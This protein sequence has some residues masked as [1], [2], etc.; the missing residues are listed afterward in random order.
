MGWCASGSLVGLYSLQAGHLVVNDIHHSAA[1]HE[2]RE[3]GEETSN[4]CTMERHMNTLHYAPSNSPSKYFDPAFLKLLN[5][6]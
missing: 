2:A 1:K 3:D 5:W 6:L 4:S